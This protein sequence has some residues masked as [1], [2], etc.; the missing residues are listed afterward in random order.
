[1][2]STRL[3]VAFSPAQLLIEPTADQPARLPQETL[4]GSSFTLRVFNSHVYLFITLYHKF[5]D[6]YCRERLKHLSRTSVSLML[7]C[8]AEVVE[9]PKE[10][11]VTAKL[12]G[13]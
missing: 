13:Q 3:E 8:T 6:R 2:I 4:T 12:S 10:D 5:I 9:A 7:G 11:F 1:M